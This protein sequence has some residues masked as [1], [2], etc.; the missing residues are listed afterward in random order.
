MRARMLYAMQMHNS[1]SNL[2]SKLN[3]NVA[4]QSNHSL[5]SSESAYG[6]TAEKRADP[7]TSAASSAPLNLLN[8][9]WMPRVSH[10][11][12]IQPS[13]AIYNEE[14]GQLIKRPGG[15]DPD[16][17]QCSPPL[18]PWSWGL[19]APWLTYFPP[20]AFPSGSYDSS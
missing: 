6:E 5:G 2:G 1:R 20:M 17:H 13:V 7:L 4:Q 9:V 8:E 12:L 11:S 15:R 3:D 10:T 16:Q 14:E 18:L 19:L